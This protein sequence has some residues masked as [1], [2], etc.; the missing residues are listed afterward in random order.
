MNAD[1]DHIGNIDGML[2]YAQTL[3][4]IQPHGEII[5]NDGNILMVRTLDLSQ[6]FDSIKRQL[7]RLIF[8]KK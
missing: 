7:D 2:L 6:D 5:T 1:K 8:Y 3:S 4:D